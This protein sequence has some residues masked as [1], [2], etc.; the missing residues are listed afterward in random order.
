M[1]KN[2]TQYNWLLHVMLRMHSIAVKQDLNFLSYWIQMKKKG[3][4]IY[5]VRYQLEC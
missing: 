3:K 2:L 1:C 4:S 5:I